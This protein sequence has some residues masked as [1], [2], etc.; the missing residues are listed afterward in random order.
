MFEWIWLVSRVHPSRYWNRIQCCLKIVENV[1]MQTLMPTASSACHY[2]HNNYIF[3]F[4][5]CFFPKQLT[6]IINM[7]ASW[8][9]NLRPLHFYLNS[10]QTEPQKHSLATLHLWFRLFPQNIRRKLAP[11]QS[12]DG[13]IILNHVFLVFTVSNSNCHWDFISLQKL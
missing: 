12:K 10:V 1:G 11:K 4:D 2:L 9:L 8:E 6:V 7:C 5:T 13:R 3:A